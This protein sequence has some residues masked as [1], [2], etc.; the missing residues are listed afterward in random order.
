MS[1]PKWVCSG[2]GMWSGRRYSVKRH[3]ANLHNAT[4]PIVSYVD[5]M[6]GAKSGHYRPSSPP[7]YQAKTMYGIS[8]TNNFLDEL[9]RAAAREL[10]KKAFNPPQNSQQLSN[11][12]G[13]QRAYSFWDDIDSIFALGAYICNKCLATKPFKICPLEGNKKG[14]RVESLGWCDPELLNK[15]KGITDANEEIRHLNLQ[16]PVFLQ[17]LVTAW[18]ENKGQ[19]YLVAFQIPDAAN[20]KSIELT[21]KA[22]SGVNKTIAVPYSE[23]KCGQ[24]ELLPSTITEQDQHWPNRVVS[25]NQTCLSDDELLDFLVRLNNNTTFGFFKIISK[26]ELNTEVYLM[27]ITKSSQSGLSLTK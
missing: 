26:D 21:F 16:I 2:C 10:V 17:Q 19:S 22:G 14:S 23:D 1:K 12:V 11:I 5:Y 8:S 9:V 27:A 20:K 13:Q 7:I 24:L 18:S 25:E 15:A 4:F 6:R 3:I